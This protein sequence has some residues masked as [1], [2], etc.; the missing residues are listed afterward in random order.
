MLDAAPRLRGIYY[1]VSDDKELDTVIKNA[2]RTL[3]TQK[4]SFM[5]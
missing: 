4:E 5:L 2:R 1:N 3:E